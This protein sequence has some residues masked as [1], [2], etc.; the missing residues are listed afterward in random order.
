MRIIVTA[1]ML[2][3][4]IFGLTAADAATAPKVLLV[5]SGHGVDE[6][7]TRPGFE[8]DEL[9]QAYLLFAANG[10]SVDIASPHGGPVVADKFDA[11]KLYNAAFGNDAEAA[12]KLAKT[13]TLGAVRASDYAAVMLIGGKGAMFDLPRSTALSALLA[14][15]YADGG[16]VAAVCHGPAAL[17][18]VRLSDGRS[19][20]AGRAVTGF[21]DEEEALFGKR[22]APQ[23]AFLL[24]TELRRVGA[25]FSEA[26]IMLSHVVA[27]GHLITGQNPYSLPAATEAVI[28]ALGRVPA[29]RHAW[30]DERSM[31]LVARA[32]GGDTAW[33]V[34]ELAQDAGLYDTAL[35]AIWGY[36]RAQAAGTDPVGLRAGLAIMELAAPHYPEPQLAAAIS[37]T[38]AKLAQQR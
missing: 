5:V 21:T 6:G 23:F 8:M 13:L 28:R 31:A 37:E 36:Y 29:P 10:L 30:A 22:W 20:V 26:D 25:R 11:G 3:A 2:A 15:T 19:L 1:V 4:V 17:V 16:V 33:A 18:P 38:R 27:D 14:S 7:K 32:L 24:E 34:A 9:T 12:A 35:I